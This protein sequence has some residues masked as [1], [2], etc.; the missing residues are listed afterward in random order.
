MAVDDNPSALQILSKNLANLGFNVSKAVSGEAAVTRVNSIKD[1]NEKIPD[2]LVI[3]YQMTGMNGLDTWQTISQQ[4]PRTVALLTV[5]GLCPHEI[6]VRAKEADFKAVISKPIS[7]NSLS[8]TLTGLLAKVPQAP[9]VKKKARSEASEQ[10]AHL[11]GSLILLVEDN[12]VNQLVATSI[13]KK[14]GFVVKVA[15][16]GK[17]AVE[18]IQREPFELVLMDIQMPEMDGLEATKI[19]RGIDGYDK[20][21]IVAMTAHAMSGDRELSL[22]SGMNDHVNKPIDVQELFKAI[23]KWLPPH[24]AQPAEVQDEPKTGLTV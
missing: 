3:D 7:L 20:I 13:L 12:E 14:A 19:I 1:K 18:M 22:K 16:N 23:A 9:K 10:V 5:N 11:K 21:P 4:M 2:L 6:Q 15:N 17:E 24:Q 8:G